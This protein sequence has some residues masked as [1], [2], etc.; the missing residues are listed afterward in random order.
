MMLRR[1]PLAAVTLALGL[2]AAPVA[3]ARAGVPV[4]DSSVLAQAAELVSS[5]ASQLAELTNIFSKVQEVKKTIG[6]AGQM[7]NDAIFKAMSVVNDVKGTIDK[8]KEIGP[9]IAVD[10]IGAAQD[11]SRAVEDIVESVESARTYARDTMYG[12]RET[13]N[14]IEEQLQVRRNRQAVV[15]SSANQA[16]AIALY[17]RQESADAPNTMERLVS[18]ANSARDLRGDV[19]ANTAAMVQV[20]QQLSYLVALNAAQLELISSQAIL[21]DPQ[22]T[23]D[24]I[25]LQ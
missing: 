11:A 5:N 12:L 25:G 16:Y 24:A 7:V 3:P 14:T 6:E 21:V 20:Y 10:P 18:A 1:A 13:V 9:R 4:I 15:R 8:F 23:R 19:A 2:A 22:L 17:A